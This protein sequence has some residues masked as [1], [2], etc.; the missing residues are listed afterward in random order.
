M[1][2]RWDK[3]RRDF[4]KLVRRTIIPL[5]WLLVITWFGQYIF[6]VNGQIDWFRLLLVYGI[7]FGIPYMFLVVPMGKNVTV[8]ESLL[9]LVM[10][11][12]VGSIFGFF[13]AVL[14]FIM[15]MLYIPVYFITEILKIR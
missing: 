9:A 7:P 1:K 6:L 14:N 2:H 4:M 13:I 12:M 15:A 5:A 3:E 10:R 8:A 11:I